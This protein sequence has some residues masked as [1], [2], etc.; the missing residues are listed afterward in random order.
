[1]MV[2]NGLSKSVSQRKNKFILFFAWL[3][4]VCVCGGAISTLNFL[5]FG[6]LLISKRTAIISNCSVTNLHYS[7]DFDSDS[8]FTIDLFPHN[9][10]EAHSLWWY[11]T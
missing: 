11:L 1:M 5:A 6:I 8:S 2:L 9:L 7:D 3:E 4:F 10:L